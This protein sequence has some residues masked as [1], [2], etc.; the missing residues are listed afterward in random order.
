MA[1]LLDRVERF[2]T[3][4]ELLPQ[5]VR[6]LVGVSGG[7]DSLVL[8]HLLVRLR[9][10]RDLHLFAAT[11][12]HGIRG[13]ASAEDVTFV[14]RVCAEWGVPVI[15]GR[16]DVPQ[17]ARDHG[18]G[19]EDAARRV[20]YAF[21]RQSAVV[22]GATRI[23]VGHHRDDQAETVLMHLIRGSGLAG[24]RGMMPESPLPDV[25]YDRR[26]YDVTA[27]LA[28]DMRGV[29]NGLHALPQPAAPMLIRPL[30]DVSR[31][32]IE[33]YAAA[34]DLHPR[35]DATNQDTTY[36]RNR[37]RHEVIPLLETFNPAITAAVGRLAE[38]VR[39]DYARLEQVWSAVYQDVLIA[40]RRGMITLDR[41]RWG[42]LHVSD[43]RA[44][45]QQCVKQV[46]AF[47]RDVT[48]VHVDAVIRA[49]AAPEFTGQL[50]LPGQVTL[51]IT[52]TELV[53]AQADAPVEQIDAPSLDH[54]PA[55]TFTAGETIMQCFGAWEFSAVTLADPA[56]IEAIH[57]DPLAA[58]LA[59]RPQ[60]QFA[61]RGRQPGDVFRPRGMGGHS[62]KLK[63][64]LIAMRVPAHWR[65]SVPLLLA[66]G[67]IAWF[68]APTA[69][70]LRGRV[71]ERFAVPGVVGA[72]YRLVVVRWGREP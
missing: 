2:I 16:A 72:A 23:A 65:D 13:A 55:L 66:D 32:E 27:D 59:V 38:I 8:L 67:E 22:V 57:V 37:L 33:A 30:L 49:A 7:A 60:T 5:G 12:D 70:G 21:L 48:G 52:G 18:W 34:H 3:A 51:R 63:D 31:A 44:T 68:V 9:E 41:V 58:V 54:S 1:D 14:Q 26:T 47:A 56:Q 40:E 61:L 35:E 45:V 69:D 19:L 17:I 53:F 42:A 10:R 15:A 28:V 62:Q 50:S 25:L 64:T 20:R 71:G 24:L 6:V 43:Q 4:Q 11:L 36:S 46:Q 39:D 29:Q